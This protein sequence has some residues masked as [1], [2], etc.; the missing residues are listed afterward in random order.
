[1]A[2]GVDADSEESAQKALVA[3]DKKA[4]KAGVT[5]KESCGI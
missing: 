4:A 2:T 5:K 3:C 1:M